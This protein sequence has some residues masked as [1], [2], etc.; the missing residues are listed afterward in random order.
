MKSNFRW[1]KTLFYITCLI[2]CATTSRAK[3]KS[4]TPA[5]ILISGTLR[6]L[7]IAINGQ[8]VLSLEGNEEYVFINGEKIVSEKQDRHGSLFQKI[9]DDKIVVKNQQDQVLLEI[10][11]PSLVE[12]TSENNKFLAT[13]NDSRFELKL[14]EQAFPQGHTTHLLFESN[15][16]NDPWFQMSHMLTITDPVSKIDRVYIFE[17]EYEA[18]A[19]RIHRAGLTVGESLISSPDLDFSIAGFYDYIFPNHWLVGGRFLIPVLKG[20]T[21]TLDHGHAIQLRT[22]YQFFRKSNAPHS[23]VGLEVGIGI[24]QI[25][26]YR[27]YYST[28]S[29]TAY[30]I[31]R[32]SEFFYLHSSPFVINKFQL[33]FNFQAGSRAAEEIPNVLMGFTLTYEW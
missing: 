15:N 28:G 9:Q 19:Q 7:T 8:K 2:F 29:T 13:L 24:Q 30:R 21:P 31:D 1:L 22:G 14:D 18:P 32:G 33:G 20:G 16:E 25:H 3:I 23:K 4:L 10:S 5:P 11:L 27:Q 26:F 6:P 12:V 17:A